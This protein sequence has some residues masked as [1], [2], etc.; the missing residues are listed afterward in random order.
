MSDQKPPTLEAVDATQTVPH[1][2]LPEPLQH[3]PPVI[4]L[5][6]IQRFEQAAEFDALPGFVG[7]PRGKAVAASW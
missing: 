1:I 6:I 3:A 2:P 7:D 5:E 4:A